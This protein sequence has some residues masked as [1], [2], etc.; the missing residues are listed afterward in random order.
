M[1]DFHSCALLSS[2]LQF[3]ITRNK[4]QV[5]LLNVLIETFDEMSFIKEKCHSFLFCVGKIC[6][7]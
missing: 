4:E 3:N 5:V 7:C 2:V 1:K 6:V